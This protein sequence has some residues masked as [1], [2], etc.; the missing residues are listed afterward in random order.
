MNFEYN[1]HVRS[2]SFS[3]AEHQLIGMKISY[4]A[5]EIANEMIGEEAKDRMLIVYQRMLED[6]TI[7]FVDDV[8]QYLNT[9]VEVERSSYLME[10]MPGRAKKEIE[11]QNHINAITRGDPSNPEEIVVVLPGTTLFELQDVSQTFFNNPDRRTHDY[12]EDVIEY[13]GDLIEKY[14]DA[15]ITLDGHSMA[16]KVAIQVGMVYPDIQVNAYN[17]T[18]FDKGFYRDYAPEVDY[19]DNIN[20]FIYDNE[21]AGAERSLRHKELYGVDGTSMLGYPFNIHYMNSLEINQMKEELPDW[22]KDGLY[23]NRFG[24]FR[25]HSNGGFRSMD[26]SLIDVFNLD[27]VKFTFGGYGASL[28][29]FDKAHYLEFVSLLRNEFLPNL[30]KAM[31]LHEQVEEDAESSLKG[32]FEQAESEL[33]QINVE[34]GSYGDPRQGRLNTFKE[35]YFSQGKY[36]CYDAGSLEAVMAKNNRVRQKMQQMAM[37]L[38]AA[39]EKFDWEDELIA[40]K[41]NKRG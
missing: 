13:I 28:I 35:D 8:P 10:G 36:R 22:I 15:E 33:N 37:T 38:E 31:S 2:E 20:V 14:P 40:G 1:Q 9:T 39:A 18:S 5:E 17:P 11:T 21:I 41:L 16:G 26:G 7:Q 6:D 25:Q 19:Y 27:A 32:V 23:S 30:T 12:T 34:I 29:V 24:I 4:E 3:E